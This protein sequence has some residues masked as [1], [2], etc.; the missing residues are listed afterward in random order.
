M[1][2]Q[3]VGYARANNAN[4]LPAFEAEL[5]EA[6]CSAVFTD[7]IGGETTVRPGLNEALA[8]LKPGD[9]LIL[10]SIDRLARSIKA[11]MTL[12]EEIRGRGIELV[13]LDVIGHKQARELPRYKILLEAVT[14]GLSA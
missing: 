6:G 2:K 10:P 8:M 5:T 14:K 12:A 3:I 1:S 7:C 13:S 4:D 9:M 11:H